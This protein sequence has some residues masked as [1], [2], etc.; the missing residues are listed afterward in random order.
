MRPTT[1]LAGALLALILWPLGAGAET[2]SAPQYRLK[3]DDDAKIT[4]RV[5]TGWETIMT[6]EKDGQ[7][8]RVRWKK[9]EFTVLFPDA[10]LR[11][12]LTE[13]P[14]AGSY[15]LV[16]DFEG[17]RYKVHRS[18]REVGWV[19]PGQEVFFR[20][21]GG[22]VSSVIGTSDYLKITRDTRGGRMSLESAAGTS[23]V[24]LRN[25]S[26]EVFAGPAVTAH[27]YF[28]RGLA[29]HRG[30][31]TLQIPLPEE[32]F[33]NALPKDRYLRVEAKAPAPPA[34]PAEPDPSA[35]APEQL[36][37]DTS[38]LQAAPSTW[39]SPELRANTGDANDDPMHTQREVRY[40][41]KD[42]PLD[43]VPTKD[44]EE[45]LRVKDY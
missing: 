28:V 3:I 12:K 20:T 22:K 8:A 44:S 45:V 21:Y 2:L 11:L 35:A 14:G 41:S 16:T 7:R 10:T 30:P 5:D 4:Q 43:A 29:F 38:P 17:A 39:N 37:D 33:L 27:L 34:A 13:G 9:G 36:Q 42:R 1:A 23:D 32:P 24:L 15:E 6:V 31:I 25:G 19:L 40:P 18:P 26:L